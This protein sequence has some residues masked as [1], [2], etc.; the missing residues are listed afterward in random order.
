MS[1]GHSTYCGLS[2]DVLFVLGHVMLVK[3]ILDAVLSIL[4]EYGL[5]AAMHGGTVRVYSVGMWFPET[6]SLTM[7]GITFH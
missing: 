6:P 3:G 7:G 1:L 2:F 4:T 5:V